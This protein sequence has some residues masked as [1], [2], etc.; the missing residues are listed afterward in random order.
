VKTEFSRAMA[1][2]E[3]SVILLDQQPNWIWGNP[4]SYYAVAEEAVFAD[5]E[6]FWP[7][8]GWQTRP[9]IKMIPSGE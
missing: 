8:S 1:R 9:E 7:V 5:P 4:E 3:F 2:H 6:A